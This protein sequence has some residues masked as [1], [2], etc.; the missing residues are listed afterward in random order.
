MRTEESPF[1][2][3]G[4]R[5][6]PCCLLHGQVRSSYGS[7]MSCG[8]SCEQGNCT[9]S[10]RKYKGL[11]SVAIT[12]VDEDGETRALVFDRPA[13]DDLGRPTRGNDKVQ[14]VCGICDDAFNRM[15]SEEG[16]KTFLKPW[17]D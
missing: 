14:E 3:F 5:I 16:V 2:D 7:G 8:M 12:C 13:T 11:V 4:A 10:E 17:F 15:T 9:H 6:C 1:F